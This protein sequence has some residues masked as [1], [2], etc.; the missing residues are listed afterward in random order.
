MIPGNIIQ[1]EAELEEMFERAASASIMKVTT[2][3]TDAYRRWI[4]A[5]PFFT[6]ATCGPEGL[7]CSPRGDAAGFLRVAYEPTRLLPERR[8]TID[9]TRCATS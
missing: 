4:E 7:D 6:I 9:W 2:R 1:S 3:L 8:G 5:A